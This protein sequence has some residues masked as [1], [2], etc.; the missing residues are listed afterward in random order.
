MTDLS[1]MIGSMPPP[2]SPDELAILQHAGVA[3]VVESLGS[4]DGH[5]QTMSPEMVR[6]TT[7]LSIA[8]HAVTVASGHNDN[9]M[10]HVALE[11]AR[12]GQVLVITG[13]GPM[14]VSWGEM[15]TVGA[16]TQGIVGVVVDGS[17]RD[18]D[19][20]DRLGFPV[21]ATSVRPY[22]ANK[23]AIGQVNGPVI[24]AGVHVS[25]GDIIVADGDGVAAVPY[26]E[27]G[28]IAEIAAARTEREVR[29]RSAAET[30]TMPGRAAGHLDG[31]EIGNH[32]R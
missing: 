16:I 15:V 28:P 10:M 6:R 1:P 23:K 14:G 25:P 32:T 21:W 29:I 2:M 18:I 12:P 11:I 31:I 13:T 4:P 8:G 9:L 7:K 30:G 24:C 5:Y 19:G 27:A 20:I 26:L 17:V 22:G 3:T